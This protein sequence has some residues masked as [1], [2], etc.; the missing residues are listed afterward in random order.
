MEKNVIRLR[1]NGNTLYLEL[2]PYGT[3][4][5]SELRATISMPENFWSGAQLI[6]SEVQTLIDHLTDMKVKMDEHNAII[7][8]T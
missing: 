4:K 5:G 7:N 6:S 3:S 1:N 2:T 8:R